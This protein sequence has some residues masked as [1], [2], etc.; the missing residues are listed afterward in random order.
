MGG[1]HLH[2]ITLA[3][4]EN[5]FSIKFC[6][7]PAMKYNYIEVSVFSIKVLVNDNLVRFL[8]F[9]GA[10]LKFNYNQCPW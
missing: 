10:G 8:D 6:V 4:I 9:A 1:L 3:V 5:N 2:Y 7:R